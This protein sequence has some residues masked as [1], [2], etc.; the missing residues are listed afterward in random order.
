MH[1]FQMNNSF[2]QNVM[3]DKSN[4]KVQLQSAYADKSHIFILLVLFF[5][6][7]RSNAHIWFRS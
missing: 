3:Y 7:F 6:C 4:D 2:S 1:D 5:F